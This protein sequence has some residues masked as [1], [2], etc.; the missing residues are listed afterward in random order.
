MRGGLF[1]QWPRATTPRRIQDRRAKL[2]RLPCP[3]TALS[4]W[5]FGGLRDCTTAAPK[6]ERNTDGT[7]IACNAPSLCVSTGGLIGAGTPSPSV[8]SMGMG[9]WHQTNR[10]RTP[11]RGLGRCPGPVPEI[12]PLLEAN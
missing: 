3:D 11:P 12:R 1:L 10:S 5:S 8:S 6:S 2:R 9:S 7:D 4:A